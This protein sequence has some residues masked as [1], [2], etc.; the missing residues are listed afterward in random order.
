L[1]NEFIRETFLAN[2]ALDV[3]AEN[4]SEWFAYT[5]YIKHITSPSLLYVGSK[6]PSVNEL[7]AFAKKL[8]ACRIEILPNVDHVQAYWDGRLVCPLIKD[9]VHTVE[10]SA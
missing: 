2:D 6:E 9:F 8:P 5:D 10:E 7:V 4:S 3:W 1:S